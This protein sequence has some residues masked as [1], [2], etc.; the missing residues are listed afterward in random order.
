MTFHVYPLAKVPSA[1]ASVDDV[2]QL[3]A[4]IEELIAFVDPPGISMVV[5]K[6]GEVVHAKGYGLADGPNGIPASPDSVY[7][8][9]SFTKIVTATATLQLAEDGLLDIHAPVVEYLPE[10]EFEYPSAESEQVTVWHLLTHNAGLGDAGAD[11]FRWVHYEGDPPYN[12]TDFLESIWPKFKKLAYEPGSG[13][14]YSNIDY[15]VLSAVI[16]AVSGQSYESYVVENIFEPLGMEHTD[17]AYTPAMDGLEAV[18]SHPDDLMSLVAA[19]TLDMDRAIHEKVDGRYWFNRVYSHQTGPT[20]VISTPMDIAV[21]LQM[22][23]NGGQLNGVRIL[24][25]ESVAM[26]NTPQVE[27]IKSPAPV[28]DVSFGL[29]WFIE[30]KDDGIV[31]SHG[32]SGLAY[33]VFVQMYPEKNMAVILASNSTYLGPDY[34]FSLAGL[35]GS[36]DW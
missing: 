11:L 5:L 13:G 15:I 12:Q 28:D 33:S 24:S 6:D 18:G 17:Y 30:E 10:L 8:W 32:G 19:T 2:S 20:G 23:L 21:F 26:M 4:Y 31:L 27:A 16:E 14:R 3:E 35:A 7:H 22:L 9:W 36:L 1:P 29:G 34:G 25:D